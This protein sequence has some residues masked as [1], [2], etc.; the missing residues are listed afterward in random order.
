MSRRC[1]CQMAMSCSRSKSLVSRKASI[2]ANTAAN[3]SGPI[4]DASN[5][6]RPSRAARVRWASTLVGEP[7]MS[8]SVANRRYSS[9]RAR[10]SRAAT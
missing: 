1:P 3:V 9:C 10:Q 4:A 5:L 6:N 2:L 7:G 8:S